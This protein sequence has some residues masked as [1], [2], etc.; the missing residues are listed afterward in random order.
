LRLGRKEGIP[1][2]GP[3]WWY[4]SAKE[5]LV[6]ARTK[7][8]GDRWHG[9]Q[10]TQSWWRAR[11]VDAV[12]FRDGGI[13]STRR[14]KADGGLVVLRRF[15]DDVLSAADSAPSRRNP[16]RHRGKRR[17]AALLIGC[18]SSKR[19]GGAG[20]REGAGKGRGEEGEMGFF[21]VLQQIEVR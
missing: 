13:W 21:S 3:P 9:R 20:E 5:I 12:R 19:S 11:G 17:G 2:G 4:S 1:E 14:T 7:G 18:G 10:A 8:L 16:C 6:W 15:G